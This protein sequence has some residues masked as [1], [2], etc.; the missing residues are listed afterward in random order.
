MH[1][2]QNWYWVLVLIGYWS[3]G[4][5]GIDRTGI[6]SIEVLWVLELVGLGF[7]FTNTTMILVLTVLIFVKKF[8]YWL[9]LF[10]FIKSISANASSRY[11]LSSCI[12]RKILSNSDQPD[13]R[14]SYFSKDTEQSLT[15]RMNFKMNCRVLTFIFKIEYFDLRN[16]YFQ[17]KCKNES[18]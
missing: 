4:H 10:V 13:S 17:G 9:S 11:V 18:L 2:H 6:D 1:Q 14:S 16:G 7:A 8:W 12:G 15:N 5:I 3:I